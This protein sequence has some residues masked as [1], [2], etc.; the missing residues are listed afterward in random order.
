M[1]ELRESDGAALQCT[2]DVAPPQIRELMAKRL[3]MI[4][5]IF[6][7]TASQLL[8]EQISGDMMKQLGAAAE[9][10]NREIDVLNGMLVKH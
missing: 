8:H 10:L 7:V 5:T 9:L 1:I 2:D 4:A 3:K 6:D